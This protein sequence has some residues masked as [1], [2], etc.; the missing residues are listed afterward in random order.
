MPSEQVVC[1]CKSPID[2]IG[3]GDGV[4]VG[5]SVGVGD[6]VGVDVSVG[7]AVTVGVDVG[8]GVCV[9]NG[10][11]VGAGVHAVARKRSI[12]KMGIKRFIFSSVLWDVAML[13][14]GHDGERHSFTSVRFCCNLKTPL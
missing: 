2:L 4:R 3:V 7:V 13:M 5:V 11:G 1:K 12:A 10:V 6:G 8:R 14:K 9:G